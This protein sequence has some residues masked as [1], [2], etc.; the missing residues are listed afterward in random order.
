M[1]RACCIISSDCHIRSMQEDHKQPR[2]FGFRTC[3]LLRTPR[4]HKPSSD[5]HT[6]VSTY[7]KQKITAFNR[8][9]TEQQSSYSSTIVSTR[10]RQR[11]QAGMK[12]QAMC[13]REPLY[14]Y[15]MLLFFLFE[16][17]LFLHSLY[18]KPTTSNFDIF[19][20]KSLLCFL[21]GIVFGTQ[22]L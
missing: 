2:S 10:V 6:A 11:K 15:L 13:C 1:E 5:C 9:C 17:L 4:R 3:L 14:E 21:R 12:E 7:R 20:S 18:V 22:T 16:I 8:P 19:P